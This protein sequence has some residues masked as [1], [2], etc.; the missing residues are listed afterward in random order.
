[1]P[2]LSPLGALFTAQFLSAFVDNMI[3]FV[4]LAIIKRDGYPD[5][6]LPFIQS[7][8]LA[9][10]VVLSPWV[11]RFADRNPKAR[12][13]VIGNMIKTA[14]VVMLFA[15]CGPALSYAAVGVGA[16][17][18]SPAKYGI[19]PSLTR[20]EDELLRANSGLESYTILAILTGSMAGGFLADFSIALALG[21]CVL[22]Y[23][24]SIGINT[25][26]PK[27]PGNRAI[28]YNNAIGE[29]YTDTMSLLRNAQSHYS[30][31]GT[32]SF[33]MA[34]A[35]LRMIVFAW[36]PLTLGI[37]SGTSISM[38]IA[39]TGVGIAVGAA[40]TPLLISIKTYQRTLW[41]GLAMAITIFSFLAIHNLTVAVI[42]LLLVG[43]LGGLYIVP[44][45]A[46]LQQVGHLTVGAGKTIA[47]QNFM[48]NVFMFLGVGAYTVAARS[49]VAVNTSLAATGI[50]LLLLVGYLFYLTIRENR[51]G[52][53]GKDCSRP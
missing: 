3:L 51:D 49:G 36:V 12:V 20:G 30:L 4:V 19:L 39:A 8:F 34:A 48:E 14:G 24:A 33:W 17:I 31:I 2:R 21:V 46:C 40:I 53:S 22:L 38:I 42:S 50:S 45:N 44:M 35:V 9:S 47:V 32:G 18:Y 16:V 27:F 28:G 13:L 26:I 25:V 23:V 43:I 6:Y 37:T 29:F 5:Y 7:I 41:F 52:C 1:M 15:G 11:G 10:Y